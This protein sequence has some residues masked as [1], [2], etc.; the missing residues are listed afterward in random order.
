[1]YEKKCSAL[2]VIMKMQTK[3]TL[4]FTILL[5]G[6]LKFKI[7]TIPNIGENMKQIKFHPLLVGM[8]NHR[9]LGKR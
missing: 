3:T 6:Q 2:L 8:Q 5:L 4:R 9:S 7:L 1:M